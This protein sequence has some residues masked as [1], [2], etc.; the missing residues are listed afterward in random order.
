MKE[1]IT[2]TPEAP[3]VSLISSVILPPKGD[4]RSPL[5]AVLEVNFLPALNSVKLE[6]Y[7]INY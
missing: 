7:H 1:I 3:M 6:C 2:V 5:S 4:T